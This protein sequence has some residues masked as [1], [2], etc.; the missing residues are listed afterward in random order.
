M[1]TREDLLLK[2]AEIRQVAGAVTAPSLRRELLMI[3]S[4]Y[5]RLAGMPRESMAPGAEHRHQRLPDKT[6]EDQSELSPSDD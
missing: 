6:A 4:H 3:A 2:A 1:Q 5:E